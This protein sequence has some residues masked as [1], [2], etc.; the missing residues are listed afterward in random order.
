LYVIVDGMRENDLFAGQ[1]RYLECDFISSFRKRIE[2]FGGVEEENKED[3]Y[4]R[5]KT[6]ADARRRWS[7]KGG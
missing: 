1:T 3:T 2:Q 7:G 5:D 6:S 4:S